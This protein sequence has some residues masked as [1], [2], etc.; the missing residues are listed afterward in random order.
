GL[1][2]G[3][4]AL[5]MAA[6]DTVA[7]IF[8][9]ITVF[10]D[11]PFTIN[12]RIKLD[13][14]DGMITEIGIRCTRLKTFE[15]RIVTIP[16]SKFTGGMV[17]NVSVEPW[18]KVVLNIGL[19][20]DTNTSQL[21]K[22]MQLLKEIGT[23]NKSTEDNVLVSFNDF[24]AS[25]LGVLFIYYIRKEGD[26]LNTQSAINLEIKRRFEEHGLEMAFPTQTIYTKQG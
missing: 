11:K 1:G 7:N 17:E 8:G 21:E 18:R 10:T 15:G 22:A 16:N 20:Y 26:I 24:G 2:I 12:D 6:K 13:G 3:G 25:A 23:N 14:F 4:L 5:A 9:G 19:V